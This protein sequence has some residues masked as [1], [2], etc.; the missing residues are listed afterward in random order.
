[1]FQV[2]FVGKILGNPSSGELKLETARRKFAEQR[3]DDLQQQAFGLGFEK[4]LS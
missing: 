1:M 3:G 2:A 4:I